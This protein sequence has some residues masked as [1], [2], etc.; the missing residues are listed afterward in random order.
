MSGI[1]L[2]YRILLLIPILGLVGCASPTP[3]SET[4]VQGTTVTPTTAPVST[5]EVT[6]PETEGPV[7]LRIWVPPQ[8]DPA[9]DSPGGAI[10]QARLDEFATRK[11][12]IRIEVRVKSVDG[13]GGIL[14]TLTTASAAAPLALPD[15]VALPRHAL[16]TAAEV[17]VLHPYDG[18]TTV[19]DDPDWYDRKKQS[20]RER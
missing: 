8:F 19:L 20:L 1:D 2:L 4:P 5:E 6:K 16:E 11:P 12:N 7:T 10:F 15:L 3:A 17:G 14:D 13:Y 9:S 18:L